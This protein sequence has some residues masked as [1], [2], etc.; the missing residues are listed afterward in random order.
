MVRRRLSLPR[1]GLMRLWLYNACSFMMLSSVRAAAFCALIA[2]VPVCA[3]DLPKAAAILEE[4]CLKCH[5]PSVRMS[6][7][8]LASA[9]DAAKGGAHGPAI[10]A[11]MPDQSLLLRMISGEK[12]KMPMQAP[13]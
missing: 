7:L 2:S 3:A 1:R 10:V 11:G 12:P 8:S 6:G 13:R 5:N 4:H 9:A